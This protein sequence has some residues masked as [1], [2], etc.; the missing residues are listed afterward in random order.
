MVVATAVVMAAVRAM[1]VVSPLAVVA[2]DFSRGALAGTPLLSMRGRR[3]ARH[4]ENYHVSF[5]VL[6]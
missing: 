2:G 3:G 6:Q 4:A 1:P 5:H